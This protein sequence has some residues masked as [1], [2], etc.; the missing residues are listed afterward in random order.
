MTVLALGRV[1]T[2]EQNKEPKAILATYQVQRQPG[3]QKTLSQKCH[4]FFLHLVPSPRDSVPL[5]LGLSRHQV[6]ALPEQE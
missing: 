3:L 5:F 6:P 4:P 2:A 1:A